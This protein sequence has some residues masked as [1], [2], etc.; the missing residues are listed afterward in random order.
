M[1]NIHEILSNVAV[2]GGLL[3]SA[4]SAVDA[5]VNKALFKEMAQRSAVTEQLEA[6]YGITEE[7]SFS[8]FSGPS[9]TC[10][11]RAQGKTQ[12]EEEII[13]DEYQREL[14]IAQGNIPMNPRGY[15]DVAG[16][17]SGILVASGGYVRKNKDGA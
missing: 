10:F 1:K 6:K 7:C 15:I 17:T 9:G 16:F 5:Y 13:L 4:G 8:P 11:D 14:N 3:T 2:I 12:E